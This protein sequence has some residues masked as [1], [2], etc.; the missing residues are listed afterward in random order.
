MYLLHGYLGYGNYGDELLASLVE[1]QIRK[2]EPNAEV[3]RLSSRNSLTEHFKLISKCKELICIGGLFQDKSSDR[4]PIYYCTTVIVAKLLGKKV[5]ILAQGIGPL[6]R[7]KSQFC[8]WLAYRLANKVSVRDLN[9]KSILDNW[10]IKHYYGSDLA[11]LLVDSEAKLSPEAKRRIDNVFFNVNPEQKMLIISLRS[12]AG[13]FSGKL[14]E[15]IVDKIAKEFC[16]E[17]DTSLMILQMQ[18][19]D[20]KVHDRFYNYTKKIYLVEAKDFKPEEIIYILKNYGREIVGMRF[21][22]LIFAKIAGLEITAIASDPKIREFT[23]QI[24]SYDCNTLKDRATAH[25]TQV[26]HS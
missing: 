13:D 2:L 5:K 10:G 12:E 4:S 19:Q 3:A 1:Q 16:I 18:D 22:G 20:R 26:L 7:T 8:T 11:W 25:Y 23:Q 21:H 15:R 9:S 24:E 14:A 17:P 6:S